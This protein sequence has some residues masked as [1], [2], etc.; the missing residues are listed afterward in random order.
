MIYT[1]QSTDQRDLQTATCRV[2]HTDRL[3][4]WTEGGKGGSDGC[5]RYFV[6]FD[7][8]NLKNTILDI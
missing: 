3:L 1:D 5:S 2:A 4:E 6:A 8:L 7:R